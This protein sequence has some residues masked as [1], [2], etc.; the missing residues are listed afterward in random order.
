MNGI[1]L[2]PL[3]SSSL[4]TIVSLLYCDD[5]STAGSL[6]YFTFIN[7]NM[8]GSFYSEIEFEGFKFVLERASNIGGGE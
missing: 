6:T 3:M 1:L 8:V 5:I 4:S 7:A 2:L